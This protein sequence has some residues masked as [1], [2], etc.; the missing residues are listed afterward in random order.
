MRNFT[1]IQLILSIAF[2]HLTIIGLNAQNISIGANNYSSLGA[3]FTAINSGT[4]TGAITILVNAST[5]EIATA[6]LNASGTGSANYTSVLIYPT[7]AG[8]SISGNLGAPLIDLNGADNIT[9]DG[10]VNQTGNRNLV[11][12]NTNNSATAGTSTIRLING[13][14]NN[15]IR[16]TIIRGSG[17]VGTTTTASS[18]NIFFSTGGNNNNTIEFCDITNS[19]GNRPHNGIYSDGTSVT[20]PNTGNTVRHCN[21]FN[22]FNPTINSNAIHLAAASIA[23]DINNNSFYE[24]ALF[25]PAATTTVRIFIA[26]NTQPRATTSTIQNRNITIHQNYIGGRAPECAGL[27]MTFDPPA[28]TGRPYGF[29]GIRT[30]NVGETNTIISNNTIRNISLIETSAT[31]PF[32][33][34]NVLGSTTTVASVTDNVIGAETGTGS[35]NV[36]G[37]AATQT[38]HGIFFNSNNNALSIVENNKIGSITTNKGFTG[39]TIDR[40][41]SECKNNLIGSLTTANSI[42]SNPGTGNANLEGIVHN[43]NNSNNLIR[44]NTIANMHNASTSTGT[45]ARQVIGI[46]I[47]GGTASIQDNIIRNLSNST[48]STASALS[49][50]VIGIRDARS[51]NASGNQIFNLAN[52]STANAAVHAY[53]IIYSYLTGNSS[54]IANNF[55]HSISVST[56]NTAA[57]VIGYYNLLSTTPGGLTV[58]NN[59]ISLGNG[60]TNGNTIYGIFDAPTS[61]STLARPTFYYFNTVYIFG[62]TPSSS[63]TAAMWI[64]TENANM[65]RDI[66]NNVFHNARNNTAG[67]ALHYAIRLQGMLGITINYNNYFTSGNG[68]Q[69][70][71]INTSNFNSLLDWSNATGQDANSLAFDPEFDNAGG[72]AAVDYIVRGLLVGLHN[73]GGITTEFNGATRDDPPTM[74]AWENPDGLTLNAPPDSPA[75]VN[76]PTTVCQNT[77]FINYSVLPVIGADTYTWTVPSGASVVS[78]QGTNNVFINFGS[79]SGNIS[80]TANNANGSSAPTNLAITISTTCPVS[81]TATS[82]A[83]GVNQPSRYANLGEAF[84]AINGGQHNA[85]IT[86]SITNNVNETAS[87]VLNE[88]GSGNANYTSVLIFPTAVN[89]S[90]TGNINEPLIDFSGADNVTIDGRVNQA[91]PRSLT[92]QN[93]STGSNAATIRFINGSES[94]TVR[95]CTLRGSAESATSG[96]IFFSTGANKN[97]TLSH[98]DITNANNNRPF[99]GIFAFGTSLTIANEDINISNN[100]FFN[101]FHPGTASAISSYNIFLSQAA[102]NWTISNNSFYETAAFNLIDNTTIRNYAAIYADASTA[103]M[104]V[105]NHTITD[106]FI[107]GTAPLCGGSNLSISVPTARNYNFRGIYYRAIS[108]QGSLIQGNTIRK[109]DINNTSATTT[110]PFIG[111]H[112]EGTSTIST[113]ENNTIGSVSETGS[114]NIAGSAA[115]TSVGIRHQGANNVNSAVRNNLIGGIITNRSF[116]GILIDGNTNFVSGNT[117]GSTTVA[118]SIQINDAGSSTLIGINRTSGSTEVSDN[119]VMNMSS[120]SPATTTLGSAAIIGIRQSSATANHELRNNTIRNISGTHPSAA[121][122]IYGIYHEGNSAAL[123]SHNIHGNFIHNLNLQTSNT[124]ATI[125]GI[126]LNVGSANFYNNIISLGSGLSTGYNIAGIYDDNTTNTRTSNFYFNTV[127]IGGTTTGGNNSFGIFVVS[128][129]ASQVK[130]L[131][132]NIFANSRSGGANHYAIRLAGVLGLGTCNHNNYF[133]NGTGGIIGFLGSNQATLSDWQTATSQDANSLNLNPGFEIPGG[134]NPLNYRPSTALNG[135]VLSGFTQ[136]FQNINRGNPPTMGALNG[137]FCPPPSQATNLNAAAPGPYSNTITWTRGN[138]TGVLVILSQGAPLNDSPVGFSFTGNATFGNGSVLGNGFVVYNGTASSVN[139][140]GLTPQTNYFVN[141]FE[142]TNPGC[143]NLTALNGSFTTPSCAPSQATSLNTGANLLQSRNLSW[144]RGNGSG[145]VVIVSQGAPVSGIP[146]LATYNANNTFGNGSAVGNGFV[147]YQG[148]ANNVTVNGLSPET[149]Y[150]VAVFEYNNPPI[151]YNASPL[152]GSFTTSSCQP[153]VGISGFSVSNVEAGSFTVNFTRGNGAGVLVIA[154]AGSAVNATPVFNQDYTANSNFGAGQALGVNN[155]VVY[156]GTGNSFN[157]S[158]LTPGVTYHFA[159]YEYNNSPRCYRNVPLTASSATLSVFACGYELTSEN[160]SVPPLTAP[161]NGQLT[162]TPLSVWNNSS[163]S[164]PFFGMPFKF[165]GV[166]YTQAYINS[167]GYLWFGTTNTA[168]TTPANAENILNIPLGEQYHGVVAAIARDLEGHPL[169]SSST[170]I[171]FNTFGTSPNRYVAAEVVSFFPKVTGSACGSVNNHRI[172]YQVRF[173]EDNPAGNHPNRIQVILRGQDSYCNDRPYSFQI[174]IRGNNPN[175]FIAYQQSGGNLTSTSASVGTSNTDR[176]I[177]NP[178]NFIQG[179]VAFNYDPYPV[180]PCL[181]GNWTGAVSTDWNTADN[182]AENS[183]PLNGATI[184]IPN[185]AVR[186]PTISAYSPTVR[187]I[188]IES[189]RTLTIASNASITVQNQLNN[190]GNVVVQSGGALVQTA[191]STLAGTGNYQVRRQLPGSNT[192]YRFLGSPIKNLPT[193]NVVGVAATGTDGA[194]MIPLSTCSPVSLAPGSPSG[195]ILEL[196]ENPTNVL[197]DCAQS[198]WHIKSAG[199]LENGKGYAMRANGGQTLVFSGSEVNNGVVTVT[200]L[201]RQSGTINDHLAGGVSRGW[202]LF[203]NPYP[204][205]IVLNGLADLVPQGFDGQ[206]QIYNAATGSWMPP[207]PPSASVVLAAGQGFQIRK[208]SI[209]GTANFSFNNSMRIPNIGVPY[210]GEDDWYEHLLTLNVNGNGFNDFT[211]VFFHAD[212][213]QTFDPTMDVNRMSGPIDEPMLFTMS[214]TERMAYNGLPLLTTP[215]T[216]PMSFYPGLSGQYTISISDLETFAATTMIYLEDKKTGIW[217]NLRLQN[218]YSFLSDIADDIQRF[219]LHFEPSLNIEKNDA[220]CL[221][222]DGVLTISN[223]SNETWFA[224]LSNAYTQYSFT[225]APGNYQVANLPSGTYALWLEN[226]SYIVTETIEIANEAFAEAEFNL[227]IHDQSGPYAHIHA[228]VNEP[229]P[230]VEYRWYLDGLLVGEGAELNFAITENGSY[231][232]LLQSSKGN[233]TNEISQAMIISNIALSADNG[234]HNPDIKIFPNPSKGQLNIFMNTSVSQP[235]HYLTVTDVFGRMMQRIAIRELQQNG[236][237]QIDLSDVANGLYIVTFE[238]N[239]ERKSYRVSIIK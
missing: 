185:S 114:I 167:N 73:V 145:V 168:P 173:Y 128:N 48:A 115:H 85:A 5:T 92:I 15:N 7:V 216:V 214:G 67:S 129:V 171:I 218:T 172:D 180:N 155:F 192:N 4:H 1:R 57:T 193:S 94:S 76:G 8:L 16:H 12:E 2:F 133:A 189:N 107:G 191:N 130:N 161:G 186:N 36:D 25:E 95:Y 41:V 118:N 70:G 52:T 111:V 100:N 117:I 199:I 96:I 139:V 165:E 201:T 163:G 21:F 149:T 46:N 134:S 183:V 61:T 147:V 227:T 43:G 81:V 119:I 53:G 63:N 17:I 44:N 207:S 127:F 166:N 39:I 27:A 137:D 101:L 34:I 33:G 202:H 159:L 97:I 91:G 194:Q 136:D 230:E 18:G 79:A 30:S 109:I 26:I 238:R 181:I 233:C 208:T 123:P 89:L 190:N 3:A 64:N 98:N 20:N 188:N 225:V 82:N 77:T 125:R 182:W 103:A 13:A 49:A 151:C 160:S 140:T 104:A 75:A 62:N 213:T 122:H 226:Q 150:H 42:Q 88:S 152:T 47:S 234:D 135:T 68:G 153:T 55:I 178:G 215:S 32:Y 126:H 35:I 148:V 29:E 54:V 206:I 228:S 138:G 120:S 232:L 210:F 80:V 6:T 237:Y 195:N 211:K 222:N 11:I 74:G 229:M 158:G 86:V 31:N 66:R 219:N 235:Y 106:N 124:N 236:L 93:N 58:A 83:S 221:M 71:A 14:E 231:T 56:T 24:T 99:N 179:N 200:G 176:I 146:N 78:G 59:I 50:S 110:S 112:V 60:I 157:L 37:T 212:A 69:L 203:A 184:F 162:F 239:D 156:N 197:F 175:D 116:T 204:S 22:L 174:G 198:L 23:W 9:I 217:T 113:V 169:S 19:S 154:R 144:V 10:R 142:Y 45:T 177:F 223:P 72:T 220:T 90:I 141:I 164:I 87:A 28:T 108:E 132:N 143:Y 51:I 105:R 209:G 40:D 38:V 65:T 205:P 131:V 84:N 187:E 170:S 224:S 121:T 102:L 196:R